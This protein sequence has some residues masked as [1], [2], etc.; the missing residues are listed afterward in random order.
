[1]TLPRKSVHVK[2]WEV[3]EGD[4]VLGF[5]TGHGSDRP[6][7][8]RCRYIGETDI[9]SSAERQYYSVVLSNGQ[10]IPYNATGNLTVLRVSEQ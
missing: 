7:I 6:H 1:M 5:G 2:P 8:I 4:Y 9:G 10:E 3:L